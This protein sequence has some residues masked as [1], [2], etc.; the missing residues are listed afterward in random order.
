MG[1][2]PPAE[3]YCYFGFVFLA[4]KTFD[5]TEFELIVVLFC[6]GA[7]FDFLHLNDGLLLFRLLHF[8]GLQVLILA[9]VHYLAD[10][11]RCFGRHLNQVKFFF[12]GAS[13]C[14]FQRHDPQLR[15]V[16][17]N[18]TDLGRLNLLIDVDLFDY[19]PALL[20]FKRDVP[21]VM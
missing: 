11:G 14:F 5:V 17:T 13:Q 16:L 1:D 7:D 8:F 18:E 19:F 2:L 12:R 4:E 15:S 6:F 3:H 9:I 20:S 10:G 21:P